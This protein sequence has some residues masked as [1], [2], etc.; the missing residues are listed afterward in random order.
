L[1]APSLPWTFGGDAAWFSQTATK[2]GSP[3]AAQ[4]GALGAGQTSYMQVTTNGP[5]SLQFW[6]K[7]SSAAN[8]NLQFYINTQLVSQISGNVDWNQ[9]VS[10]LS[11]SNPVTLKWVYTKNTSAVA[12]SDAGWV[13]QVAWTPC[14]YAEHVPQMFYQD[15]SG[16]LASWVLDGTGGVRF[17]RILA[18]TG[19]WALKAAGD[20]D[21]DGVSDLL[22]ENAAGDTG[23]WFMNPDGSVRSAL[24]LFN[25]GAWEI[26]ACADYEGTGR[27]Q[28]FFQTAAGDV[29]FWR[30]DTNGVYQ[31]SQ[32]VAFMPGWKLRG[33]GDLDGDHKAELFWQNAAGTVAI[34]YHNPDGSI[35]GVVPFG[36]GPWALCGVTDIDGDGVNDLLWQTPGGDTG[37]WFMNS[38]ST[39]RTANFWW[40][41][42]AWKL[43]AAGR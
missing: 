7:V 33:A 14:P 2:Y 27:G 8:N 28:L 4:S 10:F 42:G 38:N 31:S 39:A 41:T 18:N 24:Y 17:A 3:S 37:G 15:P 20:V 25:I 9:Y 5:G 21:G 13:D 11:T 30:L 22:F 40:N 16:L 12:G 36:T 29:A 43:K 26:K 35:R 34:W 1:A 23:G 6:W 32:H 19:G